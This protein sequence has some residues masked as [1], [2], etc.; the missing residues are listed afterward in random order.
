[1]FLLVRTNDALRSMLGVGML[2]AELLDGC[3]EMGDFAA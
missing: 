2:S 3:F 1:M